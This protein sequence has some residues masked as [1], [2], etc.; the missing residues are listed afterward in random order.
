MKKI[1]LYLV[2]FILTAQSF[3]FKKRPK[4]ELQETLSDDIIIIHTNDV[5]CGVQDKIGYD[6]LMLYKKYLKTKYKHVLLVDAGDHIQGGTIGQITNGEAIIDI[7]NK[8]GY[9]AVTL[10][11][12]EFDYG[13]KQLETCASKLN[14]GYVSSNFCYRKNKT[15]IY[16]PYK[17]VEAGSKKIAFIGVATPQTLTKTSLITILDDESKPLYH[18]MTDN[19]SQELYTAVQKHIDEIRNN[20]KAD[21]IIILAHLGVGGDAL[22]ENTSAGLLHNLKGVNA[23]IDGHTHL[24][25]TY[26]TKD[27]EDKNILYAQTGTKLEYMGILKIATNGVITQENINKTIEEASKVAPSLNFTRSKNNVWVDKEISEYIESIYANFSDILNTVIGRTD[28]PLNVYRYGE[29]KESSE[30]MSRSAENGLCDLV[31]DA[32][33]YFGEADVTIMNAG[34]VREN[35]DVGDITYQEVINTMPF[36]NDV[37]VKNISGQDILD[38]LEFGVKILPGIT[39]RFPQVS[40]I[41]YK[42]DMTLNTTVEVDKDENFVKVN[43]QRRVYDVKVNGN[44]IKANKYYTIASNSFILG[45]GDG[46]SM[47]KNAPEVKTAVGVDNEVLLKYINDTLNGTVPTEYSQTGS[48]IMKTYGDVT[49]KKEIKIIHTNDVHCGVQDSIGYDGLMYFKKKLQAEY[50][51]VLLVDAGDHIQGGTMGL[52]TN[53]MA[54]ID[55]M[56]K[57]GYDVATL[58]NHEFDYQI[59]QLEECAKA[60]KCG[61]ISCNFCER[62][63]KTNSVYPATKMI[64]IGEKKIGFIGVATPQTLS[65]TYLITVKDDDGGL[66]YDFLTENKSKELHDR[67]QSHVTELKAQG[68]NYVIIVAHL[69]IGG[70]AEEENTSEGLLKSL[71]NVNVLIDGHTHLVY[72]NTTSD[73]NGNQVHF[74]QE[75]TKLTNVGVFTIYEDGRITHEDIESITYDKILATESYNLTRNKKEQWVDMNMYLYIKSIED[76]YSD[77]LNQVVGHTDFP[78][79][80]YKNAAESKQSHEQMSRTSENTLCNLVSDAMRH[81]GEADVTIMNAGSV[82]EDINVGDITYQEVINTMP[83]SN[84]VLVKNITGQNIIDALEYGVR[85]LPETTSRFPQVSGLT[86]KIDMSINS[87]VVLDKNEIFVSVGGQRRVYDVKLDDGT[88]VDPDKYYTI[89]S[90][91]FILGGGDGYS[92]FTNAELIKTAIG[93]DNEVLLKYI[94]KTL[95]GVIPDKYS[96]KEDRI[97]KTIGKTK[98]KDIKIV[99]TND[100]HCG[101]QDAIGYDGLM[102]FK[103]QLLTR[104][105]DVLLVD[106]GDHIQGGTM[107]LITNGEAIID[108]MNKIGYDV[109][110]L[111]NHEFDYGVAQLEVCKNMLNPSYISCNYCKK[112]DKKAIYDPYKIVTTKNGKKIGFIGVATIQT[113]TKT[114]LI[115]QVDKITNQPIYD[116]LTDN[117]SQE[118]FTRVQEHIDY[119]RN[120]EKVDYVIIVAHL[121]VGGDAEEENTSAGLLKRLQNVDALIDGHTHLVY[122]NT[123][124]DKNGKLVPFA[125]TGTKLNYIGVFTIFENGTFAHENYAEVPYES[126]L[127]AE[128]Y[129]VTRSKKERW[130]DINMYEYI[131]SKFNSFSDVLNQVVGYT[132]FPLNVYALGTVDKQSHDQLSRTSENAFCNLVTD[133][134]RHAG[135]ADVTIMNAGSVREDIEAGNITYQQ[136]INTMPFSNDVIVKKIKGQ[137]IL[138]ALEHGVKTLPASTSRFPQVSGITYKIDLTVPSPVI[139]DENENFVRIE[140]E[141]RVYDVLVN[142]EEVDPDKDY[143]ISSNSFILGGGDGYSMFT[144]FEITVTSAGVDNEVL[145]NYINKTLDKIIPEQYKKTEGRII[146]T[147]G[148]TTSNDIVILHT[149][150]VHCG[151]QDAIG[152]DGLM[153]YKKQ[154]LTRYKHVILADAGDHI[155]GGTMGLITNGEA[156]IEIMNKLEYDVVTLGNHEFDYGVAQLEVCEK[157]L[158]CS[159]ISTNYCYHKNKTAI[160]PGYKIIQKGD[161]KIAFVGVA[162]PQTLSKTSLITVKDADGQTVYDFLTENHSKELFDR[163][164]TQVDNAKAEGADYVIILAHLGVGG[165]AE[166]ENTSAGVLKNLR[167]V[168]AL[169]DGHTHL[170]YSKTT[171]DKNGKL[172]P[173]AQTGTKLNYIGV[174]IIHE[175]GTITHENVGEVP[176]DSVVEEDTLTITRN[177][178]DTYVDR[179]MYQ[180]IV[181]KMD[182]FSDIL[183]RV[184]GRTGFIL[185]VY[186]I[187]VPATSSHDQ[188]SR[189]QENAFCNLVTDALRYF[190]EADVTIMNAGSVRTDIDIGDIT[191][192]EVINTMPFSNDVLVKQ[193]TGQQLLDALEFGVRTL[194]GYTSR[195]PQ[196]SGIKYCI[197][198][199]ISSSVIVDSDEVFVRVGGR[200]RVYNVTVNGEKLDLLKKYTISSNSFILG[201]GD[202]YSMFADA[203]LVRTAVAVDNE[204]LLKYINETLNGAV[205]IKYNATEGRIVKTNGKTIVLSEED[206]GGF[207]MNYVNI[208]SLLLILLLL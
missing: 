201:G 135:N 87:S 1:I 30:Q 20:N 170:V 111:G 161:K 207:F 74:A 184:I 60:L 168:D 122:S 29:S 78:L 75:G 158:K 205:P 22:E 92:M 115:T 27:K 35:I 132:E 113:L 48:R 2:L 188:L 149:N 94:N 77:T 130:V 150:D 181:D 126:I 123:T 98:S 133:A 154:L 117:N 148:K 62:K 103:K 55:I 200:R 179:E 140:G 152:Y 58:G 193:I 82:R 164:Q 79:N 17:I 10:G 172:V 99:H 5:H 26:Y 88:T 13:I 139:I 112:A 8:V 52:I 54:I 46:Y 186:Q 69:G 91:S 118:L 143:T 175:D 71:E 165:D 127:D 45:G 100:V 32:M 80:V 63:T 120:T 90:N 72:Y 31:T 191:Y 68:A 183:N 65:K 142:G 53:G 16:P 104:Y 198:I 128:S 47:F 83:F 141:R 49:K 125:Q 38:A 197:D 131:R 18:F 144:A 33:R 114:Y 192:Q 6:G 190:G 178:K 12:H 185:N 106:A 189:F 40:G 19:N 4:R 93:V 70:D 61:Y 157:L 182:S 145:L 134:L 155:Q 89:S 171:P 57:V 137:T 64:E 166:E 95:E 43:G 177:K 84:D 85:L 173:F 101:V 59:P 15:V 66:K 159:Y 121:G 151:V 162:T 107:G 28:F 124:S 25:Y 174:F 81:F 109:V 24:V 129:S 7:M 34:S 203:E 196:V 119:L 3:P 102:L 73:K 39:S 96:K 9:D 138:D 56:N 110:T 76:S 169:I 195:F 146:K 160:Y 206:A 23:L 37:L 136:I 41:T 105:D 194:P 163:V 21:Y 50:Q 167:N 176:F 44:A 67:V 108:I 86:Y 204:V 147:N 208:F 36:S 156:I 153:L 42:I 97:V 187:G 51:N 116:F 199:S 11:N 14:A 202:G 180:Y